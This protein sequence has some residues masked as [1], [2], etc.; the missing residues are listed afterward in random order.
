VRVKMEL[1]VIEEGK[2]KLI[3]E[4]KGEDHTFCNALKAELWNDKHVKAAAYNID[5]PLVGE[6]H[7]TVE[8]DGKEDPKDALIAAAKRLKKEVAGFAKAVDKNL[9]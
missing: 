1:K 7:L 3:V 6:P 8:T 2:N 5:H 9:K 4:I